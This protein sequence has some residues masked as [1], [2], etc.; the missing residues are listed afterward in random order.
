M[1]TVTRQVRL[2]PTHEEALKRIAHRRGCTVSDV[3]REAVIDH[4]S[5]P[6]NDTQSSAP[7]AT[8]DI[9]PR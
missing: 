1:L 5:V 6:A 3:I 7:L 8:G 2:E 4:I 9:S